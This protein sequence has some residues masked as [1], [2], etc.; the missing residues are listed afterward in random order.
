MVSVI[1]YEG[2]RLQQQLLVN[3]LDCLSFHLSDFV[4]QCL[5]E[6]EFA[7]FQFVQRKVSC[8]KEQGDTL[9]DEG[10]LFVGQ[11]SVIENIF[12]QPCN[13]PYLIPRRVVFKRQ[14]GY[15]GCA[16]WGEFDFFLFQ[17]H[18]AALR[19][20]V[21]FLEGR[22]LGGIVQEAPFPLEQMRILERLP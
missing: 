12:V 7:V 4:F 18:L 16:K 20:L 11:D 21:G 5:T 13:K 2:I 6:S 19:L 14:L 3:F 22:K 8:V 17:I 9:I 15:F 1:S 10:R